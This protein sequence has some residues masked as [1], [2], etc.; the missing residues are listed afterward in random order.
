VGRGGRDRRCNSGR[1]RRDP[2]FP[3][4]TSARD[5]DSEI[6]FREATINPHRFPL[7]FARA[8]MSVPVVL[9]SW[10]ARGKGRDVEGLSRTIP[11]RRGFGCAVGT[12]P[13]LLWS[14]RSLP[15]GGRWIRRPA[16]PVRNW[17]TIVQPTKPRQRVHA[18]QYN[19]QHNTIQVS[20]IDYQNTTVVSSL[21]PPRPPSCRTRIVIRISV[22]S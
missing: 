8:V 15:L 7:D 16:C 5:D 20:T 22:Y 21:S 10:F 17:N 19:T 14:S 11:Q 2:R 3:V 1:V 9:E 12:L 6:R 4:L 18:T 13:E